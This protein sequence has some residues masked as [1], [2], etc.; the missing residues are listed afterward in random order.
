MTGHPAP[1]PGGCVLCAGADPARVTPLQRLVPAGY[2]RFVAATDDLVVVPTFGCFVAGYLLV[3]P[4]RHVLSFGQLDAST[5]TET[6]DLVRE[7]TTRLTATYGLPV[8]GFEYGLAAAGVRRVEHAH[9]H[10][11]PSTA[12]L[13]GWLDER[14]PGRPLSSLTGLP[15][16]RSYIAVRGQDGTMRTYQVNDAHQTHQR[17]RLR[18]AVAELEPRVDAA[19]WDWA[20]HRCIDLIRAT[21]TDMARAAEPARPTR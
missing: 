20:G 5:L 18:R 19:A 1:R 13:T 4:R 8:L 12:D 7:L 11:L 10:L 14:V 3:V 17:I 21:I 2:S 15:D 6:E 9:W 16:D